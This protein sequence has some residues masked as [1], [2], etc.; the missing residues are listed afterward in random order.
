M[1]KHLGYNNNL[2]S[3]SDPQS[4]NQLN[5]YLSLGRNKDDRPIANNTRVIRRSE[6][7]IAIRLHE[8]DILTF[9]SN[10]A[11]QFFTG[12]WKTVTTKDRINRFAP[13]GISIYS[14][15]FLWYL[16]IGDWQ[17]GKRYLFED[18]MWIDANGNVIDSELKPIPEHSPEAEKAK[19]KQLAK[20]DKFIRN[21]L[22]RLAAGEISQSE[23]D[24]W[25]CSMKQVG[26]GDSMEGNNQYSCIQSHI[27]EDYFHFS[28]IMN[29]VRSEFYDP[30]GQFGNE[31][32][33]Y[34]LA[35]IDKHN[36]SVWAMGSECG[37]KTMAADMTIKRLQRGLKQFICKQLGI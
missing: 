17:S 35:P 29:A 4:Y 3:Y 25:I 5:H 18:A 20:I 30:D 16:K 22:K 36:L 24:C 10:G 12:G 7:S 14:E 11:I 34:G 31:K 8:T 9:H 27:D 15:K 26:T 13:S 23:G 32:M 1:D 19:R 21:G 6:H 37:H 33:T 2:Y 28:L